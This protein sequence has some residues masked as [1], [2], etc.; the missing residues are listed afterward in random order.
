MILVPKVPLGMLLRKL[1]FP[2]ENQ[3]DSYKVVTAECYFE[4]IFPAVR[5]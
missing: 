3:P 2:L 4:M 5:D 1:R